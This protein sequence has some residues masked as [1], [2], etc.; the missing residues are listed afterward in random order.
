MVTT[1][2]YL[3]IPEAGRQGHRHVSEAILKVVAL[4]NVVEIVSEDDSGPLHLCLGHH[5]RLNPPSNEDVTMI[6]A[7]LVNTG[8][9]DGIL[10]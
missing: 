3:D 1:V 9:L 2:T 4:S 10:G 6:G 7:F 8:A 5:T